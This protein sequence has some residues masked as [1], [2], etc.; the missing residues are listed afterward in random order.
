MHDTRSGTVI[1]A[2]IPAVPVGP[3]YGVLLPDGTVW[4]PGS[5]KRRP[6][7][8]TLRLLVW[9]VALAVLLVGISDVIVK[10]QP[11]WSNTFR[12]V[13]AA[14]S[15]APGAGNG[16][17]T[18]APGGGTSKSSVPTTTLSS[19]LK[20]QATPPSWALA[21]TIEYT[22]GLPSYTAKVA[23]T[24]VAWVNGIWLS[25]AGI[26]E[27]SQDYTLGQG[28]QSLQAS[29][30]VPAGEDFQVEVAH[31]GVTVQLYVGSKLEAT[32][33][34]PPSSTKIPY[35]FLFTPASS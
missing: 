16:G 29:Y 31:A 26:I 11:S 4:Y 28:T 17:G 3:S 25:T 35:Y 32:V 7:P 12:H 19:V 34:V 27:H 23:S 8:P 1:T 14:P 2:E 15:N 33:P 9:I 6:A 22:V 20:A 13:V 24:G 21:N 30:A 5:K 18:S 10:L